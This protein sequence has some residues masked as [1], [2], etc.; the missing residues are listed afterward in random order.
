MKT[1]IRG[2]C[3]IDPA[4]GMEQTAD[5]R[6]EDGVISQIALAMDGQNVD[7]VIDAAGMIVA[8]GLVDVHVHFR[9]PG[10]TY[11]EDLST[12]A[13]AAARGGFTSVV[14]MANT[15]PV[16]DNMATL[17]DFQQR[18]EKLDIHVHTIAA[19]SE[20][21]R[22]QVHTNMP[23]LLDAGALGFSDDGIPLMNTAF[24]R[25]AMRTA[26]ELDVPISLHEEDPALIG[27]PGI[28]DGEVARELGIVGAPAAAESTM[29]ARDCMLALETGAR[30]HMQH[31]SCAAS[32]ELVRLAKRMG[33]RVTAEVT[34]QHLSL[35]EQAVRQHGTR[36]KLNP[37]LRTEADRQALIQAL[38]D[39]T[40]DLI[41]T[42]HAPHSAEE[43]DRPIDKAPSGLIG[44]ETALSLGITHLVRPGHL[45]LSALLH[46]MT[47]APAALY[48]L[49]AGQLRVGGPADL[50]LFRADE[51]WTV[52]K[53]ASKS[54]NSPFVGETLYGRVKATICGGQVVYRDEEEK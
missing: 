9:D 26:K 45:S 40:I 2:G 16:M 6:I 8:P 44:L 7:R 23:A 27:I 30:V 48:G 24:L 43:K 46:R 35:T 50:V 29:V 38:A 5:L 10:F 25:E 1:L 39:G 41:A 36:A 33:A 11:K 3:V 22:G 34:P 13:A 14:C 47:C 52:D 17:Q 18:A 37:P 54:A 4:S 20:G 32:V 49:D 31:L 21:L 53:F 51:A 12:G 42:D 15:S 19:V 28:H